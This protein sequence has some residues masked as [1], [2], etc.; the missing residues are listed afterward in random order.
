MK[1]KNNIGNF[2]MI[3]F[4]FLVL[5]VIMDIFLL[6]AD[7]VLVPAEAIFDSLMLAFIFSSN[8]HKIKEV[9]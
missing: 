1:K 3:F 2:L 4:F 6:P 5:E 7:E 9:K 8:N